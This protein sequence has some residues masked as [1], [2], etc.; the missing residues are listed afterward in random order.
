MLLP[1]QPG[2]K[3]PRYAHLLSG[4]LSADELAAMTANPAPEKARIT[5]QAENERIEKLEL[6]LAALRQDVAALQIQLCELRKSL[7]Q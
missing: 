7:E 5:L 1:R 2:R 3:E 4:A 6:E